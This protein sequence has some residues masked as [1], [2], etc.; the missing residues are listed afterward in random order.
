MT[1]VDQTAQLTDLIQRQAAASKALLNASTFVEQAAVLG[2]HLLTTD[3]HFV[4]INLLELDGG[5]VRIRNMAWAGREKANESTLELVLPTAAEGYPLSF[6]RVNDTAPMI[7]PDMRHAPELAEGFREWMAGF[8]I[9]SFAGFAIHLG[10]RAIGAFS[11]NSMTGPID[12]SAAEIQLYQV[13]ADQLSGMLQSQSLLESTEDALQETLALYEA[14][15]TILEARDIP[16]LLQGLRS[17]MG[18][19]A[20]ISHG[21]MEYGADGRF[22]EMVVKTSVTDG[23]VLSQEMRLGEM[24]GADTLRGIEAYWLQ[25]VDSLVTITP[26]VRGSGHPA[27]QFLLMQGIESLADFRIRNQGRVEEFVSVTFAIPQEFTPAR[28]RFLRSVAEQVSIV[29]QNQRLLRASQISATRMQEQVD[30]LEQLNQVSQTL[31]AAGS[32]D[33]LLN[34]ASELL[35]K[36]IGVDHVGITLLRPDKKSA[37]V[38]SE[39]PAQGVLGLEIMFEGNLMWQL[40]AEGNYQ[41]IV[42]SVDDEKLAA[43]M[44]EDW[45]RLGIRRIGI[46]PLMY[47]EEIVGTVG[48]DVTRAGFEI[49]D[50]MMDVAAVVVAQINISLRNLRLIQT[51]QNAAAQLSQQVGSLQQLTEISTALT[52][53]DT[54]GELFNIGMKNL[55]ELVGADHCGFV[56]LDEELTEGTVVSEYPTS[57]GTIGVRFP[58]VGNPLYRF[59]HD[60]DFRP[61][62]INNVDADPTLDEATRYTLQSV[63]VKAIIILPLVARGKLVGSIGID[64]YGEGSFFSIEQIGLAQTITSQLALA[65]QNV[66]LLDE[67]KRTAQNE[68][69]VNE[70]SNQLQRQMDLNSMLS[71]TAMELGKALGARTARIRLGTETTVVPES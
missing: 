40:M 24:M 1:S 35:V 29:V 2:K 31:I 51:T 56:T 69:L 53:A 20:M 16:T 36:L 21:E 70:V 37:V 49:T 4:T 7:V 41:P 66:R 10:E 59:V 28:R 32:E 52:A 14:N 68:S 45:N 55:A 25:V 33:I 34:T 6:I 23:D 19:G 12:L 11:L 30:R 54:E 17:Q 61:V 48:L 39:Y 13:L 15:R 60:G 62:I 46:L 65:W 26:Q 71:I 8:G 9:R 3:E 64:L 67:A 44:R 47:R 18:A 42:F 27:E 50:D 63:N 5:Q 58:V 43:S 38:V 57:V 22:R